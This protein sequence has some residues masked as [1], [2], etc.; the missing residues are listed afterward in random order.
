MSGAR[1]ESLLAALE[2]AAGTPEAWLAWQLGLRELVGLAAQLDHAT[3]ELE[4]ALHELRSVHLAE[5]QALLRAASEL[6]DAPR[7]A[8]TRI[9][10]S[11]W[12]ASA[13]DELRFAR[14]DGFEAAFVLVECVLRPR[15]RWRTS[16]ELARVCLELARE[17]T[18]AISCRPD[19]SHT[20]GVDAPRAD[21]TEAPRPDRPAAR[22]GQP[23]RGER[24]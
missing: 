14:E 23:D 4:R 9:A 16:D 24:T 8:A 2:V 20:R 12:R 22:P 17:R 21:E 3:S 10:T 6:R 7:D 11:L 15:A 5:Q 1:S 18:E 19:R 13:R